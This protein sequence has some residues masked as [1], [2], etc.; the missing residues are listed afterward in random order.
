MENAIIFY[1]IFNSLYICFAIYRDIL[2]NKQQQKITDFH[3][4]KKSQLE[5][6]IFSLETKLQIAENIIN[7][8]V[9]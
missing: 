6:K 2:T 1:V 5:A 7:K 8:D 4:S 3:M 9:N